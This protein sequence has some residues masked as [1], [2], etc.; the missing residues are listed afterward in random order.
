M[1]TLYFLL[2]TVFTLLMDLSIH[3]TKSSERL[4]LPEIWV[5]IVFWPIILVIFLKEFFS[6]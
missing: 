4:T 1:I 2:G 5:F 3:Y 6:N